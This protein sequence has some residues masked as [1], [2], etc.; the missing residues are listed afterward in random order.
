[1]CKEYKKKYQEYSI[2][3]TYLN[4]D[5]EDISYKGINTSNWNDMLKLY[6][7]IKEKYL[8]E[9]VVIYFIGK[10]LDGQ[11]KIIWHKEIIN[12]DAELKEEAEEI[13]NT[14]VQEVLNQIINNFNVLK[15]KRRI[16]IKNRDSYTKE[17]DIRLHIMEDKLR[18]NDYVSPEEKIAM[19]DR[20]A[21]ERVIRR[22]A[23][24]DKYKIDN[25]Y[26]SFNQ[27]GAKENLCVN[28]IIE[29]L[30]TNINIMDKIDSKKY[31]L[32]ESKAEELKIMKKVT[33]RN[34]KD[35]INK[36]KQLEKEFDKVYYDNSK[37]EI[38]CYNKAKAC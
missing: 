33:Y 38:T 17:T 30:E 21:K 4:G 20:I 35:R 27:I 8:D 1:M 26:N 22:Q 23:K 15:E 6:R 16:A 10:T 36:T 5:T 19:Y 7:D 9:S 2:K 24:N 12:K 3:I 13:A 32:T 18:S 25:L 14:S 34:F 28:D 37:M 11:F 31:N 29:I